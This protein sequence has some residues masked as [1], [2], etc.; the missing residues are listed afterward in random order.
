MVFIVPMLGLL[1][2]VALILTGLVRRPRRRIRAAAGALIVLTIVSQGA[3]MAYSDA[4]LELNPVIPDPRGLAGTWRHGATVFVLSSDGRWG[5]RTSGDEA[6]C[7]G[8]V[9]EGRWRFN[10]SFDLDFLSPDGE[11]VTE[12]RQ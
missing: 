9:L 11:E 5:C 2:G 6:P 7:T 12:L 4:G 1:F 10:G 8:P 3:R